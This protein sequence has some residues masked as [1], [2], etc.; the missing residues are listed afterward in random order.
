MKDNKLDIFHDRVDVKF[1]DG[2]LENDGEVAFG[3]FDSPKR[4]IEI[5]NNDE[6]RMRHTLLHEYMHACISVM[7]GSDAVKGNEDAEEMCV[8]AIEMGIVHLSRV[9][10]NRWAWDYVFGKK[11]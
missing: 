11:L 9:P 5:S 4:L 6:I 2:W 8:R 7:H 10:K 3:T 1:M